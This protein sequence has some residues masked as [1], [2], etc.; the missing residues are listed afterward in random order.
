VWNRRDAEITA[1]DF[2]ERVGFE[3][4]R[5]GLFDQRPGNRTFARRAAVDDE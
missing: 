1:H 4:S 2:R 3:Q 5:H